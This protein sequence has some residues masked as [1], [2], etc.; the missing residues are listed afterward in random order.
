MKTTASSISPDLIGLQIPAPYS[1]SG[2]ISRFLHMKLR[3]YPCIDSLLYAPVHLGIIDLYRRSSTTP[4]IIGN[5]LSINID[6]A[7]YEIEFAEATNGDDAVVKELETSA[8]QSGL[9]IGI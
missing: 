5:A 9:N 2:K 4:N 6:G 1:S 8:S 3:I 7:G